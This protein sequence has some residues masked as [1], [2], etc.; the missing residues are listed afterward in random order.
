M[1]FSIC[2]KRTLL[3]AEKCLPKMESKKERGHQHHYMVLDF[4]LEA[5]VAGVHIPFSP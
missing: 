4:L 2:K 1:F 5:V 3:N